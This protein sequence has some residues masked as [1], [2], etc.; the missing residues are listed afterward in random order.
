MFGLLVIERSE[1]A[2]RI[3]LLYSCLKNGPFLN[4]ASEGLLIEPP[5]IRKLNYNDE[6]IPYVSIEILLA[7]KICSIGESIF[8]ISEI[9]A[10]STTTT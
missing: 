4:I 1:R 5:F 3:F 9:V 2:G 6:L 7:S 10:G 8:L